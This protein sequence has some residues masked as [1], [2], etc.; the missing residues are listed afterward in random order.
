MHR[1]SVIPFRSLQFALD[2]SPLA[3][4]SEHSERLVREQSTER[5]GFRHLN[6][7]TWQRNRRG[8]FTP[9]KHVCGEEEKGKPQE[10]S[11]ERQLMNSGKAGGTHTLYNCTTCEL[12]K[13]TKIWASLV[14]ISAHANESSGGRWTDLQKAYMSK[15]HIP[16]IFY[17]KSFEVY[18][19]I[20]TDVSMTTLQLVPLMVIWRM[21]WYV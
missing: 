13:T 16:F 3:P 7:D 18:P 17:T 21:L 10:G 19:Q 8:I 12:Q 14:K 2:F 4:K 15:W 1:N 9:Q 20:S 11:T 6:A 5:V